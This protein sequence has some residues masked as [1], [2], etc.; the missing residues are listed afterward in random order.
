MTIILNFLSS[1]LVISVSLVSP[2]PLDFILFFSLKYI[3]LSSHFVLHSL[4]VNRKLGEI[5]TYPSLEGVSLCGSVPIQ[6]EC[7]Q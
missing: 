3:P 5:V 7:E 6:S 1:K 2:L 4:F